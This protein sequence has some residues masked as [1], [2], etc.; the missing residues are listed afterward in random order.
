MSGCVDIVTRFVD[1]LPQCAPLLW[2]QPAR[3]PGL[4][5][6]GI[7]STLLL[8][9][10]GLA[11]PLFLALELQFPSQRFALS[12]PSLPLLLWRRMSGFALARVRECAHRSCRKEESYTDF[13]KR[14]FH[15]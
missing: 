13:C 14:D 10:G 3:S 11:T 5:G 4:I 1:L 12:S 7:R 2:A 15:R 9:P 6:G 8:A